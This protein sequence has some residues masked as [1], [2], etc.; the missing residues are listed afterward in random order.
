MTLSP[1]MLEMLFL[2]STGKYVRWGFLYRNTRNAL[3]RRGLIYCDPS[4]GQGNNVVLTNAGRTA[5]EGAPSK[6]K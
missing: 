4:V 1:A 3:K 5:L 2:I 6:H